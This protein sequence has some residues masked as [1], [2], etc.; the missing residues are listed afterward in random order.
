[1][2]WVIFR[3]P[4]YCTVDQNSYPGKLWGPT[5]NIKHRTSKSSTEAIS[6]IWAMCFQRVSVLKHSDSLGGAVSHWLVT[7][8]TRQG[9]RTHCNTA[10]KLTCVGLTWKAVS[11]CIDWSS[12]KKCQYFCIGACFDRKHTKGF[13]VQRPGLEGKSKTGKLLTV[14]NTTSAGFAIFHCW[15]LTKS[16]I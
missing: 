5:L 16:K 3:V 4:L 11:H 14:S 12:S 9:T 15:N 10:T 6:A 7:N 13:I 2:V 1:M 8:Y